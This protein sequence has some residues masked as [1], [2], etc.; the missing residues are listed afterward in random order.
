MP[1]VNIK[2]TGKATADQKKEVIKQITNTLKTVLDKDPTLTHIVIDE[3]ALDNWGHAG[4][5]AAEKA[6]S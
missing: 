1:F 4:I 2:I 5:S 6:K 3:V